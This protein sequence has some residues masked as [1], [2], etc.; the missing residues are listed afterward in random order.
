MVLA[1]NPLRYRS[2]AEFAYNAIR[3]AIVAGSLKPDE[4]LV[5]SHLAEE[6]G[7]SEIPVRE[8][9]MQLVAE[10]FVTKV[11]VTFMVTKL[12]KQELEENYVI[13]SSLEVTAARTAAE[14]IDTAALAELEKILASMADCLASEDYTQYGELN[15]EF[16]LAI[17][18]Q[19]PY[20]TLC[21]MIKD[22]WEHAERTRSIF[23]LRSQTSL[24][25]HKEHVEIF[26]AL[27]ARDAARVEAVMR[28]HGERT[29][30]IIKAL[31][32]NMASSK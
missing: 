14:V 25:S 23:A 30:Q 9:A 3:A 6:L 18:A 22:L 31:V 28:R 2:K 4:R 26:Q 11:G 29:L 8:A 32:E 19:S 13:R 10:G 7:I 16:H 21:Q 27:T 20:P 15:H 12:S 1:I 17:Y 24:E 5:L